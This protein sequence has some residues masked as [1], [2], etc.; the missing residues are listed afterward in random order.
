MTEE[1]YLL[2]FI[3][4]YVYDYEY[5]G[6]DFPPL[7]VI[8]KSFL[9]N[10]KTNFKYGEKEKLIYKHPVN[11]CKCSSKKKEDTFIC[12]ECNGIIG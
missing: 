4:W 9:N 7:D 6:M 11:F 10:N 5:D 8:V 2:K 1:E 3:T 12:S